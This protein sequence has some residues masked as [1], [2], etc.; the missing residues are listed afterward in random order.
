MVLNTMYS[1]CAMCKQA[2]VSDMENNPNSVAQGLNS[3]ILYLMVT[4]YILM[5][6]FFRKQ[7]LAFLRK[8]F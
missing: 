2:A 4:P 5:A 3:G 8:I 6:I 1:Q 7:I